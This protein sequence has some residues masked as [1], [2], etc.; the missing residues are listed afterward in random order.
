MSIRWKSLIA[1]L[2]VTVLALPGLAQARD[3]TIASWGGNYQDAQR[4]VYFAPFAKSQGDIR[5]LEE[6]Y[7]GGLAQIKAMVETGNVTWDV[8]MI[9]R[10]DLIVGCDEGLLEELDWEAVGGEDQ[11]V[12]QA[13]H[14]CGAGNV[15]ISTGFAYDPSRVKEAP[16]DYA[17]FWNVEKWPGKRGLRAIPKST[18]E[19]ALIADGVPL[20]QVYEVL[21]TPEGLDRAFAKLDEIKPHIQFWEAGAQPVEWLAAGDVVMSTAYNGRIALAN[22]EG[23]DLAFV[24]ADHTYSI[25]SWAIVADS[26]NKELAMEFIKFANTPE[27][28]AEFPK[29]IPYGPTNKQ[30]A[31][32]LD[33]TVS[34][35]L[36]AGANMERSLLIDEQFW[37]DNVDRITERWNAWI[38]Q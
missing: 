18:L 9:E 15:V 3:F 6:T 16:K 4:T 34:E 24:W 11:L 17:D 8:L 28:Q 25:D 5:I 29:H 2:G 37:A 10:S 20:E 35:M 26:P 23:R 7:L 30:A 38:A 31:E 13:V 1:G 33:P 14:P 27:P 12:P 32:M 19:L 36:P 22:A 21:A